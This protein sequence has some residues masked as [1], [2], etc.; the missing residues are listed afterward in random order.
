MLPWLLLGLAA[1]VL[2]AVVLYNLREQRRLPRPRVEPSDGIEPSLSNPPMPSPR[3]EQ[4]VPEFEAPFATVQAYELPPGLTPSQGLIQRAESLV[5][6]GNKTAGVH[7]VRSETGELLAFEVGLVL[8]NR[9]GPLTLPDHEAWLESLESLRQELG[10]SFAEAPPSFAELHAQSREAERRLSALDGQMVLHIL[11]APPTD[12]RLLQ[13]AEGRGLQQ[14]AGRHFSRM[15]NQRVA[16][17]FSSAD[18][19]RALSCLMDLPR[20]P[21]PEEAYEAM[22]D[23]LLDAA[24]VFDGPIVDESNRVLVDDDLSLIERQLAERALDLRKAGLEPGGWLAR[25]VYV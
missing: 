25:A 8:A 23:D 18:G 6:V 24:E 15:V 11:A 3:A 17:T 13:W 7:M 9:L 22:V 19:G 20:C 2:V 21:S 4:E 5:R 14:R 10:A 16:Y 1:G 12:A